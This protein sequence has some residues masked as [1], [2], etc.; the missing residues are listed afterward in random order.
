MDAKC[1][2]SPCSSLAS[3]IVYSWVL[4][5]TDGRTKA[6]VNYKDS[7]LA[8]TVDTGHRYV[9]SAGL[10]GRGG[11]GGRRRQRRAARDGGVGGGRDVPPQPLERPLHAHLRLAGRRRLD[12]ARLARHGAESRL[13]LAPAISLG[14]EAGVGVAILDQVRRGGR[15]VDDG[16]E[17]G[18]RRQVVDRLRHALD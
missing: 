6:K 5:R 17:V 12:E 18:E 4:K 1:C 10:H 11:R 7:Q 8:H 13:D 15:V 3:A 14:E 2:L 16:E 9:A